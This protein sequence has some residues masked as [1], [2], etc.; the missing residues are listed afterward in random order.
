MIILS[1]GLDSA[2]AIR[3]LK[4]SIP[5]RYALDAGIDELIVSPSDRLR[6][7]RKKIIDH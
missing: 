3:R 7:V 4:F 2:A 6:D 1:T 5:V